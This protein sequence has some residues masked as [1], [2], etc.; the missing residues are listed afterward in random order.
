[1]LKIKSCY[2]SSLSLGELSMAYSRKVAEKILE[3]GEGGGE[4]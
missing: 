2:Y 4:N 3:A 1:M